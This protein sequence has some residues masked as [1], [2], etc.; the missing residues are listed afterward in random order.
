MDE[1]KSRLLTLNKNLNVLRERE[2][3]YGGNAPLDLLTQIE[4]HETAIELVQTAMAGKLTEEELEAELAP[5]NL[6]LTRGDQISVG[7]VEGSFVAIGTGAK[8]IVNRALSAAEE[9]KAQQDLEQTLLA[10]A[11]VQLATRLQ[12]VVALKPKADGLSNP[13]KALLDYRLEDAALFYGRSHAIE[14]MLARMDRNPLTVLHAESGAGKT[15]LLQAGLASRL[16]AA[17]DLPLHIRP[18]NVNPVLA[19][20]RTIMPNLAHT[21]GLAQVSLFDFLHRVAQILGEESHLYIFLDQFEEFF[22][23]HDE[24]NRQDF[25][26]QLG[27][28][29]E[30]ESLRV[31][32]VLAMRKEYFGNL[33][34]FRPQIRNPFANDYLLRAMNRAEATEVMVE[35]AKK[36]GVEYQPALIDQLLCDLSPHREGQTLEVAPPQIQLVCST[37]FDKFIEHRH[38]D[39][40]MP[41]IITQKM[42]DDEGGASGILRGHLNRV[43]QR[44]FSEQ[45]RELARQLL[46]S[47]V[48]SDQRRVRRRQEELAA[49]LALYLTGAQNL[50][51]ILEQLVENRL[52][53]V[54]EDEETNAATFELA[55]DYLLT[56]IEVDPEVQ[57]QKAAQ[58][59][60]ERE[61]ES[62]RRYGTVLSRDKY[63]IINSQRQ[64]LVL[65]DDAKEFL[66][67]SKAARNRMIRRF[68]IAVAVVIVL[69]TLAAGVALVA[70]NVAE[71]ERQKAQRANQIAQARQLTAQARNLLTT[72]S[73]L[74]LLLTL[75][76]LDYADLT[77][78][79]DTLRVVLPQLREWSDLNSDDDVVS[80]AWDSKGQLLALGLGNGDIQL[81]D[82]VNQTL[83]NT[84]QGHTAAVNDVA[85]NPR[86]THLLSAADNG[87]EQLRLWDVS[88]G[89]TVAILEGHSG[90]VNA[91]AWN[92]D[93]TRVLTGG[94]DKLVILW[95]MTTMQPL[96]KL[97]EH[98]G[99]VLD[100]GWQPDTEDQPGDK[101]ASGGQNGETFIWDVD[102]LTVELS[103]PHPNVTVASLAWDTTGE[104]LA[105][106]SSDGAV[107]IWDIAKGHIADV[108]TGH[109]GWVRGV[110]WHPEGWLASG[111]GDGRV[112]I[113]DVETSQAIIALTGHNNWVQDVAWSSDGDFIVSASKDGDARIWDMEDVPGL[114]VL[115]GHIGQARS[116]AWH[117]QGNLLAS[118]GDDGTVHLWESD[119]GELVDILEAHNDTAY[120]V[121]WSPDGATLATSSADKTVRLWST[122]TLQLIREIRHDDEVNWVIFSPDGQTIATASGDH[123]IRLWDTQT[124]ELR[125]TLKGHSAAVYALDY[126]DDGQLLASVAGDKRINLWNPATGELVQ[127]L[128][129][130]TD[131]VW[132]VDFSPL[133]TD[134]K[135][136][137][138]SASQDAT[139]RIWDAA[140]GEQVA[141][142]SHQKPVNSVNWSE[143]GT[144]L[145]TASDDTLARIWDVSR[146]EIIATLSGHQGS[147]WN[148]AWG[149]DDTR[150]A[151]AATDGIVRIFYTDFAEI[152][153]LAQEFKYR[154]L[155]DE[156]RNKYIGD[157]GP[158]L[159]ELPTEQPF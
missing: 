110:G 119:T 94:D 29:L 73:E 51:N 83:L 68:S 85:F 17:G 84:L 34:T 89:Q 106:G 11:V 101:F 71:Q 117:P 146:G 75:A 63:D 27:E 24:V 151:T 131:I 77:E 159:L 155:T 116:I 12:Q 154:D 9:A 91:V 57:A 142:Y 76:A 136:Y 121:T 147:V 107:R 78:V 87:D 135:I 50:N 38:A 15:S 93:G 36:Q 67:V 133:R 80:A 148:V 112:I 129:N 20:K 124:G 35:P 19:I 152:L 145:A 62:F 109:T 53:K 52:L 114:E 97:A 3:K 126:S 141:V 153:N 95:D 90:A 111:S 28:C 54:E 132:D 26:N 23:L 130:H 39:P 92:G 72:D 115:L 60:L 105:T 127:T 98:S 81:W 6:A 30:D 134:G 31:R 37:L 48:S 14:Q 8:L 156:E 58:E 100:V 13:Y 86:G 79:E 59:L 16:L 40:E 104:Q 56:E 49:T 66:R 128:T 140:T 125:Q 64:F 158:G 1:L 74:S 5:L 113:W 139:A 7:D 138:A 2:A 21:P 33:A 103:L 61:V 10:E 122:V 88:S 108:L 42:Y 22:T 157:P 47:L 123:N 82:P 143:D 99:Q 32:W 96:E 137:L 25:I 120:S 65:D 70:R 43:L 149:A 18:W 144:R 69:L 4:D 44:N 55:H 102:S 46:M 41:A 150:L 45:E 118:T